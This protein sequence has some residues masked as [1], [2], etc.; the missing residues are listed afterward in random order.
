MGT[1]SNLQKLSGDDSASEDTLALQ[2]R[3]KA[4]ASQLEPNAE[5]AGVVFGIETNVPVRGGNAAQRREHDKRIGA[6]TMSASGVSCPCCAAISTMEDLRLEGQSN[7]L[8][9]T[10][11]AVVIDGPAGELSPPDGFRFWACAEGYSECNIRCAAGWQSGRIDPKQS[12]T[13]RYASLWYEDVQITFLASAATCS[14]DVSQLNPIGT[15]ENG[16]FNYSEDWREA[17]LAYLALVQDRQADYCSIICTW[18]NS[19][20]KLGHT[21]ARF[22]LPIIWDYCEVNPISDT[23]GNFLGGVDW[24]SRI[25][26]SLG[27]IGIRPRPR[28]LQRSATDNVDAKYDLVVTDPP[29]YD[30]IP[31]SDISNFFYVWLKRII[32]DHFSIISRRPW[33]RT[34]GNSSWIACTSH[35]SSLERKNFMNLGWRKPLLRSIGRLPKTE[36]SLLCSPIKIQRHGKLSSVRSFV[37]V[38]SSRQLANSDRNGKSVQA[39]G[40]PLLHL[41]YGS[42]VKTPGHRK[43]RMGQPSS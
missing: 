2:E 30:A 43:A 25:C 34:P 22:A 23:S 32:G 4:N 18:H 40:T 42:F 29:Y 13:V 6:G 24:F 5:N 20:E 19:G 27:A 31:Y 16:S 17:V 39:R 28:A 15:G 38:S 3:Q 11:T 8:G 12:E 41:R 14:R 36:D 10:L 7:R 26:H 1:Y 33:F 37:P 21:F 9:E 35:S